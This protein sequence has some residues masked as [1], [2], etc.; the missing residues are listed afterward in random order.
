M[1]GEE[2]GAAFD[3]RTR[4]NSSTFSLAR[5]RASK[6]GSRAAFPPGT[7]A[8]GGA[9]GDRAV[10]DHHDGGRHGEGR[11]SAEKRAESAL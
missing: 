7:V 4:S 5:A 6:L 3:W 10:L 1:V 11:T 9:K 8:L 2:E